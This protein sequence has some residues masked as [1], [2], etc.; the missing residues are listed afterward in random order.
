[1]NTVFFMLIGLY[2]IRYN[3]LKI[4]MIF[5]NL[6]CVFIT[7]LCAFPYHYFVK[8]SVYLHVERNRPFIHHQHCSEEG[9]V[10]RAIKQLST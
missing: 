4:I 10:L 3:S 5:S 2:I 9:R 6:I 1:M 7:Q 8:F